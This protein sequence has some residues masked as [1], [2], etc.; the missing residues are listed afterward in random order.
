MGLSSFADMS[1][2]QPYQV[3]GGNSYASTGTYMPMSVGEN[4]GNMMGVGSQYTLPCNMPQAVI[5]A[6]YNGTGTMPMYMQN[7]GHY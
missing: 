1:A 6:G 7:S 5:P 3:I 2:Y 4:F